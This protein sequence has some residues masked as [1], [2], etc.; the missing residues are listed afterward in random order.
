MNKNL[1]L[2]NNIIKT[3]TVIY[4]KRCF[5]IIIALVL[6]LTVSCFSASALSKMGSRSQE[7]RDIQTVLKSK[8][9]Y[10]GNVDGIFGTKT[11]NAVTAF[12]RDNGLTADGIVGEK[13]LKALGISGNNSYG[14]Y[15]SDRKS[16][17]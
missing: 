8:G 4:V 2:C 14:G 1:K 16:V 11:K 6:T 15:S 10:T 5:G 7:V 17:V 9:Y 13:T 3:F 12:Q